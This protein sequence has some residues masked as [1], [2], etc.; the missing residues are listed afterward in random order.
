MTIRRNKAEFLDKILLL[1]KDERLVRIKDLELEYKAD[2]YSFFQIEKHLK[3]METDGLIARN[4]FDEYYL[5]P[6][7][8]KIVNDIDNLGYLAKHKVAEAKYEESEEDGEFEDDCTFPPL[9]RPGDVIYSTI[10]FL[11]VIFAIYYLLAPQ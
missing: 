6:Q 2:Y 3:M 8:L 7:G 5:Q 4:V 1:F 10:E 9:D 11:V